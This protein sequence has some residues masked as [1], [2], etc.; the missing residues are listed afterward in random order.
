MD[1]EYGFDCAILY[2]DKADNNMFK[3][4]YYK[5][6][7]GPT[8]QPGSAN[9]YIPGKGW[10]ITRGNY[11][12]LVQFGNMKDDK[13]PKM[14]EA[15]MLPFYIQGHCQVHVQKGGKDGLTFIIGGYDGNDMHPIKMVN[16]FDWKLNQWS[17][18]RDLPD[19]LNDIQ[20]IQIDDNKILATSLRGHYDSYIYDI[21]LDQWS[22][23][24]VLN[25]GPALKPKLNTLFKT[26]ENEIIALMSYKD[27]DGRDVISF[28][29]FEF[30][31][32]TTY[33][34][35]LTDVGINS[36]Y[37]FGIH[38]VEF[39]ECYPYYGKYVRRN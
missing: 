18:S 31:E 28:F 38:P 11:S 5:G 39:D 21:E 12:T 16:Y 34:E 20:C 30:D 7:L 2:P 10:W 1:N 19:E 32:W 23:G 6:V 13:I 17:R 26:F 4:K 15:N 27:D 29:K 3:W 22:R 14:E 36:D 37:K 35:T 8:P 9:S 24:P 25:R 33:G